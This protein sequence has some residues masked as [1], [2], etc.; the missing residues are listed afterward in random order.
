MFAQEDLQAK[1][2]ETD[3][4]LRMTLLSSQKPTD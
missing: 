3:K 4:R 1:D 2:T